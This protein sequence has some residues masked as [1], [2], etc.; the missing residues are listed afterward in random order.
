MQLTKDQI[1][2]LIRLIAVT[3][4]RELDCDECLRAIAEFTELNLAGKSIPESLRL[5]E[6]HLVVCTD[7]REEYEILKRTLGAID[8]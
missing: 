7:C 3:E 8:E 4:K 6:Q 1:R 5:V 2:S